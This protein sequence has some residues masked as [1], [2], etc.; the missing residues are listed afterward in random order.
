MTINE[1]LT[2]FAG[3][4]VVPVEQEQ[5]PADATAVAWNV[6]VEDFEGRRGGV[7]VGVR[8]GAGA[9]RADRTHCV[10]HRRVGFGL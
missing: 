2:T 6:S 5:G 3:L 10:D 4:P 7:R 9:H 1:Y 8:A